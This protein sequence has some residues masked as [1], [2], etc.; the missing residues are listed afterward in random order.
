MLPQHILDHFARIPHNTPIKNHYYGVF[1]RIFT[2]L[3][4]TE[5][6]F[7][8]E[9]QY[10]IP[11]ADEHPPLD[12]IID[13]VVEVNDLPVLFLDIKSPL[14]IDPISTRVD[15][16]K[17][18]R[19]KFLALYDVTPTPRLH[20]ISAMG[21][22]LSFYCLEKLEATTGRIIPTYVAP[23]TDY[24]TDTVPAERWDTDIT[25]EDGYQRFMAVIND[26]KEMAAAL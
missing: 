21:Q 7:I 12:F 6:L 3:C 20:G 5:D 17:Q 15:A 13:Y 22:K 10:P 11:R 16:D 2:E 18:I 9:P 19:A 14:H 8:V 23:S 25:T 24:I 26:V 1:N 4:F